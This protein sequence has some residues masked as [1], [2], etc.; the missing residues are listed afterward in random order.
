L[1]KDQVG[2]Q[3]KIYFFN[4]EVETALSETELKQLFGGKGFSLR[5]MTQAGIP[6]PPGFTITTQT[7]NDI[8]NS[9]DTVPEKISDQLES[10]IKKVE[11]QKHHWSGG[12]D[13]RDSLRSQYSVASA[14]RRLTGRVPTSSSFS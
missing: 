3:S 11:S 8:Y 6:V 10:D 9:E 7:W 14:A 2:N 4:E 12:R 13:L 1:Y 5:N